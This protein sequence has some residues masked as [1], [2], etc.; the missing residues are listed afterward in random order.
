MAD[1]G[2]AGAD[3]FTAIPSEECDVVMKGG[4]T[5]GVVYPSAILRLSQRYRFRNVGGASVGAIA[6]AA[7]AAS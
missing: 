7:T 4:I 2:Q 3:Q 5:S 6:A 1:T